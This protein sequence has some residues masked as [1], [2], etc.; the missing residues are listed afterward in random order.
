MAVW[1]RRA[2]AGVPGGIAAPGDVIRAGSLAALVSLDQ[3]FRDLETEREAL[4]EQAHAQA[5]AIVDEAR[6]R[7]GEIERAARARHAAAHDDGYES[8]RAAALADWFESAASAMEVQRRLHESMRERLAELVMRAAEQVIA[9][10]SS[11][12]LFARASGAVEAIVANAAMLRVV[13]HP[14]DLEVAREQFARLSEQRGLAGR[15]LPLAVSADRTLEPGAC[16]CETDLGRID[17]SLST[18]LRALRLAVARALDCTAQAA[19]EAGPA[20]AEA[21]G[22]ADTDTDDGRGAPV[23]HLAADDLDD[24]AFDIDEMLRAQGLD[25]DDVPAGARG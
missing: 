1:L 21:D 18:Q 14:D 9:A 24:G 25:D 19:E 4:I 8:G 17:A 12:A 5:Q 2:T 11:A 3:G 10:E 23:A 13:V 16:V 7:A 15:P 20:Q 22:G 6:A